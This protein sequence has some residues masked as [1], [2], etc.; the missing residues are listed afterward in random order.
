MYKKLISIFLILILLFTVTACN[1]EETN[2]K[3]VKIS[4]VLDWTPNT[5]HTGLYVA[6]EKGFFEEEGIEIELVQP[7]EDGA[8]ALVATGKAP[9]GIGFQDTLASAFAKDEP[10]PITAIAAIIQHNTSGIISLKG[11]GIESPKGLMGKRYATWDL[12]IEKAIVKSVI[13]S[14]GGNFEEINMIPTYVTD[15]VTALKTD[16]D[17]VWIFYAWDGIATKV[18]GLETDYFNFA[19]IDP[20]FD[21]Y[22]P[23]IIANNTFLNENEELTKKFLNGVRKGYEFAIENPEEAAAILI[24]AVPEL[25]EELIIESQQWLANQYKAEVEQWGYIDP[26]RWNAFY[27]WLNEKELIEKSIPENTGFSNDYLMN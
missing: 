1:S 5:N 4:V 13:E 22:S 21:Y 11:N 6:Q 25:D 18:K 15:V 2:N 24:N 14:D 7:P 8:E 10:M 19:D 26:I 16:I 3:N 9:F 20:V 17:A 23:V 12:P 27:N